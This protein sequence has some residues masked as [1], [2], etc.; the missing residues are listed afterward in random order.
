VGAR[1]VAVGIGDVSAFAVDVGE[2]RGDE[3]GGEDVAGDAVVGGGELEAT[4]L[5]VA[6]GVRGA[7]RN[8]PA[9]TDA[10][11][12]PASSGRTP[13]RR[14]TGSSSR[15]RGQKPETGVVV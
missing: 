8:T 7:A 5:T 1:V 4:D 15:H 2:V 13:M 10:K 12:R 3:V 6:E 14:P 11:A 9:T